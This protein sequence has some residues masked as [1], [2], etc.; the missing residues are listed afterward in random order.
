MFKRI[1]AKQTNKKS[2]KEAVIHLSRA[3]CPAPTPV[4]IVVLSA[5]PERVYSLPSVGDHRK[6]VFEGREAPRGVFLERSQ[7]MIPSLQQSAST[8]A[9]AAEEEE[10]VMGAKFVPEAEEQ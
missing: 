7:E 1:T 8:A 5:T 3:S 6:F 4:D 2:V 9:A 10:A